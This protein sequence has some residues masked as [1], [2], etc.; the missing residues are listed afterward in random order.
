MDLI[1]LQ[2]YQ[3]LAITRN[4]LMLE[5]TKLHCAVIIQNQEHVNSDRTAFLHMESTS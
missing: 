1:H 3:Q 2:L 5:N 4:I